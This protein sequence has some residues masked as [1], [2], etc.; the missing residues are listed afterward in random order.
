VIKVTILGAGS[1]FTSNLA[2]DIMLIPGIE[3][4]TLALVD[5]DGKRLELTR[6]V[7]EKTVGLLKV[8]WK[9]AAS[10]DRRKV[11]SGSDFLIN[12]IEVSGLAAV[13]FDYNIPKKFGVDQC[14]GDTIG[15]GGLFKAFRTIPSWIAI[16]RDAEKLCPRAMVLNYTNPMSMMTL[17]ACRTSSAQVVGLCHSVQGSSKQLANYLGVPYAELVWECAGINHMAWFTRLEHKGRDAYPRLLDRLDRRVRI[18]EGKGRKPIYEHDPVRFD[19]M[20]HFGYFVTESS[21][22]FSEY[23]P[24]YRKREE[25]IDRYCREKYL[26][27]RGFY[28]SEWPKWRKWLDHVRVRQLAGREEIKLQRSHEYASTI[29]E[30][31]TLARPAVIYG[32]VAN[33][34]LIENLPQ[35][36]VVEVACLID[37]RGLHPTHYGRLPAQVAAL[38]ASNMACFEL[39]VQAA[40]KRDRRA[41]CHAMMLDP[42]TAAVCSPAEIVKMTDQLFRAERKLLP[43]WK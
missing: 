4:G 14:I 19:I 41:A 22:H 23:V 43:G 12:T 3:G 35:D 31:R 11:M 8:D 29:I 5:I 9:I 38:C 30:A 1:A 18:G 37:G 28:A 15:P 20:R 32:S 17:A 34:G 40:L 27:G 39:G 2:K 13:K 7:V 25:L 21:G 16:L 10:T 42:L 6:R 24:Y 36:G 26:G 33:A